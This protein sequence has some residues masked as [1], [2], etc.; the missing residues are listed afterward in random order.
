[1]RCEIEKK[2][3]NDSLLKHAHRV[4]ARSLTVELITGE[5]DKVRPLSVESFGEENG[6]VDVSDA[7]RLKRVATSSGER[8]GRGQLGRD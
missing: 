4:P 8:R 1:M 6:R 2:T 3:E 7:R 5:D